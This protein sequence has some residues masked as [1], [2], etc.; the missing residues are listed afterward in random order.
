MQP[1]LNCPSRVRRWRGDTHWSHNVNASSPMR[2]AV[3]LASLAGV[4][5]LGATLGFAQA[6]LAPA[7]QAQ[8]AAGG[9]SVKVTANG[10]S[11]FRPGDAARSREEAIEAARRDAVEQVSGVF[12]QSESEM[13]NFDLVKDEVVSKSQGYIRT[14][15]VVKEGVANNLFNVTIEAEVVKSAFI[16]QM[17]DSLED[18]YRRVGKPR[19][20][21]LI[22]EYKQDGDPG[23]ASDQGI[24][25]REIRKILLAQGFNFVDPRI[26]TRSQM[27]ALEKGKE[28]DKNVFVSLGQAT[29][30]EIIML[31][32]V[33]YGAKGVMNR[34]N[35]VQADLSMDVVKTDNGQVMASQTSSAMDLHIDE[36]T[37]TTNALIKVAQEITP[38]LAEQISYQWIKEKNEGSNIEMVVKGASFG[39]LAALRRTL[40]NE[41][42]GVKSVQQRSFSQGTALLVLVTRDTT[43][44]LA[45]SISETKFGNLILEVQDVTPTTLTV[46]VKK[47]Q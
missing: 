11:S 25:A 26:V 40:S 7:N 21:V 29:K 30:A 46:S 35:R 10:V 2:A 38:K 3:V 1:P 8:G 36:N 5:M 19:V 13:K 44:R 32:E 18:L 23:Q 33:K 15:K 17:Q 34:F 27:A 6:S 4:L 28:A 31:G 9:D 39:D 43:D 20:M 24:A 45:E 22:K 42:R 12:I 41:V 37:A 47:A 14:S 16:K